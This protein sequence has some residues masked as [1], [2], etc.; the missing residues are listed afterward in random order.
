MLREQFLP[1]AIAV[2]N[3]RLGGDA[4]KGSFQP[5]CLKRSYRVITRFTEQAWFVR[6]ESERYYFGLVAQLVR[7]GRS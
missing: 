3:E 1:R 5:A 7:A 4:N 2:V 6:G